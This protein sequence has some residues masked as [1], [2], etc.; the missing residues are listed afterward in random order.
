LNDGCGADFVKVQQKPP[1]NANLTAGVRYA[2]FDGDADRVVYFFQRK[3]AFC[4]MDGDRI[5]SLAAL[6]IKETAD[7]AG[8]KLS[9][10][11]VQTA[12]ANGSSTEYLEKS[13]G[14][15]VACTKTGVKHL[16][17]KATEF[18]VG[19]YFEANGHGT[20]LFSPEAVE[21]INSAKPSNPQQQK[22]VSILKALYELI[23]QTVGD[24]I[25]DLLM[26]EAILAIKK[27]DIE[28]WAA[29]YEDLPNRQLKVAIA[30]RAVINTT[31]AERKC[32]TPAGVQEAIDGLVAKVKKGR[33]FVRPSGT[34]DVVRVYAE[35]MTQEQA[36]ALAYQVAAMVYDLAGGVGERPKGK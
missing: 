1:I 29:A 32:T 26:V 34:E 33:S 16:H 23:N 20:V 6:F 25:S 19:V 22:A 15:P 18:D 11:A 30:N 7:A 24:A 28:E 9:V 12:Y 8:L 35:A 17:H 4:L 21:I 5:A 31:D 3:G 13:V 27:I 2:S 36:D 14:V 10:G